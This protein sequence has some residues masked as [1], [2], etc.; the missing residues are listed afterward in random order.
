MIRFKNLFSDG[1][2]PKSEIIYYVVSVIFMVTA[3][4]IGISS[5]PPGII[6]LVLA[7]FIFMNLKPVHLLRLRK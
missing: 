4:A 2:H 1:L 6:M 3:F 5:N 7:V